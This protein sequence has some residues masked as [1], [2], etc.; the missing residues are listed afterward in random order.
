MDDEP[1]MPGAMPQKVQITSKEF[2]S[3]FQSK[4]EVYRFLSTEVKMYLDSYETMTIWHLRNL[5][6]GKKKWISC[7]DIKTINIP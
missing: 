7:S 4:R 2:G 3:K 6:S 5:A 1:L